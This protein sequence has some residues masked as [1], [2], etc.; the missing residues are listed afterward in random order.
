MVLILVCVVGALVAPQGCDAETKYHCAEVR[1][2]TSRPGGRLLVLD[3]LRHSYVD[4]DDPTF[5]EFSYVKALAGVVDGSFEPGEP[6]DAYHVGGGGITFPR[7]LADTRPGTRSVVSE[8]DPGVVD[9]DTERLGLRDRVRPCGSGSRTAASAYDDSRAASRDLVVGDAFGGVSVPWHLTTI[10][11]VEELRRV[12]RD[13]GV[14]AVNI[15]DFAPARLRPGRAR[16]PAPRL[17]PRRARGGPV[18]PLRQRRRQPGRDR[19]GLTDRQGRRRARLRK[20]A[21]WRGTS[22][23]ATGSPTGSTGRRCSPTTT[24]PSTSC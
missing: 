4:V 19:L 13:D 15:I 12:L 20:A 18:H 7:Y 1:S 16:H 9:V 3:G 17:R 10:E 2:D 14:Y 24:R 21:T 8:I 11:Y 22:S 6:L 23:T 5:L